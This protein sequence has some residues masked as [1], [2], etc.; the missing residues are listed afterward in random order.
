MKRLFFS[1]LIT[2]FLVVSCGTTSGVGENRNKQST[3]SEI[4]TKKTT[5]FAIE[6]NSNGAVKPKT[7]VAKPKGK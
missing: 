7:L 3:I 1:L 4:D 6:D 5:P 2:F